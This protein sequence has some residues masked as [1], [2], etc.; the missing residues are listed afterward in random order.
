MYLFDV[1]NESH[2]KEISKHTGIPMRCFREN[3]EAANFIVQGIN[4]FIEGGQLTFGSGS[5]LH[6]GTN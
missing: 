6:K 5:V 3:P 1:F 2:L 4:A